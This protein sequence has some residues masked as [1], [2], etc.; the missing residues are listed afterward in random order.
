MDQQWDGDPPAEDP[1]NW[2]RISGARDGSAA[3]NRSEYVAERLAHLAEGREAGDRLG[4]KGAL[5]ELCSVS[6]GTFNEG[7]KLAQ[8]RG[9][10]TARSGP[11][12]GVFVATLTPIKRLGNSVRALDGDAASVADAV[13]MRD[14]LDPLLIDDVLWHSSATDV[15]DMRAR[16][17]GMAQA[18]DQGDAVAFVKTNWALHR[19]IAEVTPNAILRS[20]YLSLLEIVVTHTLAVTDRKAGPLPAY[21]HHRYDLA[22]RLVDA[23]ESHDREAATSLILEHNEMLRSTPGDPQ[24]A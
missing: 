6:V 10:V 1:A 23:V 14:A 18:I 3:S 20:V 24:H 13:R 12:G 4:T 7:V 8:S 11:G 21:V 15:Q 5:R 16:L 2:R 17:A 9:Y 19:R 22:A